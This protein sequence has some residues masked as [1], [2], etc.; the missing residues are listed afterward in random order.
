MHTFKRPDRFW[1]SRQGFV[2][3]IDSQ[4]QGSFRGKLQC[5]LKL[6]VYMSSTKNRRLFGAGVLFGWLF[7]RFSDGAESEDR[8]VIA[9]RLS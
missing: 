1:H 3:Q 7:G 5:Y 2:A 4:N 8:R 6:D 9:R